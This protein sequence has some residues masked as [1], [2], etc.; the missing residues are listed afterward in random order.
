MTKLNVGCNIAGTRIDLLAYADDTVLIAPSWRR[1]QTLLKVVEVA[2][3]DIKMTFS[4]KKTVCMIFNP[5]NKRDIASDDFPAFV[6]A[7]F[8]LISSTWVI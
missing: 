2:V 3:D 6:Q 5:C 1:L 7:D 8:E 4:T